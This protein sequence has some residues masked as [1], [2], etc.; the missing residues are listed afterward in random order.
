[1]RLEEVRGRHPSERTSVRDPGLRKE[2]T[3]LWLERGTQRRPE[4]C[5]DGGPSLC[6][7]WEAAEGFGQ[8]TRGLD[9]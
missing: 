2:V 6:S 7:Q 1:M 5:L 4:A 9:F 8:V 3:T